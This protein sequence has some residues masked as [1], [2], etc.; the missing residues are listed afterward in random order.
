[1]AK[2]TDTT[3]YPNTT[4][5]MDDHVIGTDVSDTGNS[6]DGEVVTFKLSDILDTLGFI[7]KWHPYD[8]E[9]VA[10][11]ADGVIWDYSVDGAT[12][13]IETPT[14]EDG[15]EYALLFEDFVV[16]N[17]VSPGTDVEA[18]IALYKATDGAY[19]TVDVNNLDHGQPYRGILAVPECR[20]ASYHHSVQSQGGVY[21]SFNAAYDAFNK[22]SWFSAGEGNTFVDSTLQVI[23]SLRLT[24]DSINNASGGKVKL[25]R[26]R[27]FLSI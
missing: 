5:A 22:G 18:T 12:N 2:I 27:E 1:M 11:G 24:F 10:D 25:L 4:P 9:A 15:W 7:F 8:M 23:N 3:T 6:A 21:R 20:V 13:S 16:T 14:F 26:R 19:Q 17:T